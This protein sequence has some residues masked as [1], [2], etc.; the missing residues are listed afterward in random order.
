MGKG[1]LCLVRNRFFHCGE[2]GLVADVAAV[3]GDQVITHG[4]KGFVRTE[5]ST[6][7]SMGG[8]FHH[9]DGK[10]CEDEG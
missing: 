4:I 1:T 8:Y 5:S 9:F 10:F 6:K 2:A 3:E 7:L